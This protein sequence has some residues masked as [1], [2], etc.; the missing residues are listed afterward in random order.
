MS[1]RFQAHA[2]VLLANIFFGIN[3]ITIKLIVPSKISAPALNVCR[4]V[5]AAILFWILYLLKPSK[6]G[7]LKKDI[8]VFIVCAVAGVVINQILFVK[9]LSLTTSIHASLLALVTPVLIIFIAAW[10]LKEKLT[11]LKIVGVAAGVAGAAI[12][13]VMKDVS[14]TASN[15]FLGDVLV[16]LNAIAYAFYLVI[17]KPLMNR[18]SAVHVVRWVFTIGLFF[19]VPYGWNDV[20]ATDWQ[21]FTTNDWICF[22]FVL[23]GA[24]FFAYLF[25]IYGISVLGASA[26]GSYIYT[27]PVFAAVL[28]IAFTGETYDW[29][30]LLAALLIF[31]GVYLVN[32]KPAL[33]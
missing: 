7:I 16:V 29:V 27:Q 22:W 4:V 15:I 17:A 23:T 10:L 6:P 26:T 14:H 3:Y 32:R 25:N 24:T 12:L 21:N 18:Y 11:A 28:A 20:M 5:S 30:K 13:I 8:P 33:N 2:A 9:G 19:M 1:K 31:S